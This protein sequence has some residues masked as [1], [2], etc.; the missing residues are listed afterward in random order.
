M[1]FGHLTLFE[2]TDVCHRISTTFCAGQ[3]GG[4]KMLPCL[5]LSIIR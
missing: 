1:P 3:T 5:T 2:L 4:E